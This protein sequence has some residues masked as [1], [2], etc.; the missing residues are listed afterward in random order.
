MGRAHNATGTWTV[1]VAVLLVIG[2]LGTLVNGGTMLEVEL[3]RW[4]ASVRKGVA[5]TTEASEVG[6]VS[7]AASVLRDATL[8][9]KT[10]LLQPVEQLTLELDG[11]GVGAVV[12]DDS[13]GGLL[14]H[15]EHSSLR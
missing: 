13:H 14:R 1:P 12:G 11:F 10:P 3:R 4:P 15:H 9:G 6:D 2:V 5:G 7:Q 8:R